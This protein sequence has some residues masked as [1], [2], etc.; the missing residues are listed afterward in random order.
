[1]SRNLQLRLATAAV[2]I[3][4]IVLL[5]FLGGW[6]FALAAAVIVLVGTIE[7]VHGWLLPG[8][9]YQAVAPLGPGLLAPA[10][11]VAGV[12]A[13]ERFLI[14]GAVLAAL[15]AAAG[16]S[17]TNAFGPR[18]PFRVLAWAMVYPGMLF[19]TM[20]L[21][22]DL[23]DGRDWILLTLFATFTT[24]SG[25]Y[26]AGNLLGRHPLA[27]RISPKKTRE[28][29]V[30]GLVGGI[31]AVVVIVTVLDLDLSAGALAGLAVALP[32]AA[33]LGDLT[34]SWMKRRMGVKDASGLLPGH[35][36]LLDRLDSIVF[37]APVVYLFARI[38]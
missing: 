26:G 6:A 20:V 12:H 35:G 14:A 8:Q 32:I 15:F 21:L 33:Q 25:A 18:K 3:P 31:V 37:V 7:F 34:E 17:R 10:V 24:D 28:G 30:G 1:M 38:G 13:D 23:D 22:R 2:G 5:V 29:A 27:P 19:A 16:Y 4:I 11:M 36:G 9:P